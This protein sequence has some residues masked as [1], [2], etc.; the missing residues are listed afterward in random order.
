MNKHRGKR[1]FA[2]M[3]ALSVLLS[4]NGI[5][6]S[7]QIKGE[8][9][10]MATE[11]GEQEKKV[12]GNPEH[13][14]TMG[15]KTEWSYVYFGS[16]PQTEVT[17][18]SVIEAIEK[19]IPASAS[20]TGDGVDA[21]V[22][23]ESGVK[24]KYRRIGKGDAQD[25]RFE[26][27]EYRY[28][29]YEPI[30]WK[31]LWNDGKSLF[32]VAEKALDYKIYDTATENVTWE[33]C[34]VRKW[35]NESFYQA[36]FD[37]EEQKAIVTWDV[38]NEDHPDPK[39]GTEGGNDTRDNIYLLSLSEVMDET[40]GFCR[41]EDESVSRKAKESGFC[42]IRGTNYMGEMAKWRLRSPG[43]YN[44]FAMY[45]GFRGEVDKKGQNVSQIYE[46]AIC[47]S[48][49]INLSSELWS[50]ELDEAGSAEKIIPQNPAHNCVWDDCTEWN[51]VNFGSYPQ[52]EVTD[53]A[54]INNIDRV[55]S[56]SDGEEVWDVELPDAKGAKVKYRRI[57]KEGYYGDQF[58]YFKWEPIRWRVLQ[59][60]G[61]SLF[62]LADRALDYKG[63]NLEW[64]T[65]DLREW[66]NESFYQAAF[67]G[68]E[69]NAIIE[70]NVKNSDTPFAGKDTK[71]KIYVPS[72]A[73]II[74]ETYG[75]CSDEIVDSPTRQMKTSDYGKVMGVD[76]F[77]GSKRNCKWWLRSPG[78]LQ[79]SS[80]IWH[81]GCIMRSL[82]ASRPG[83]GVCPVLHVSVSSDT[84]SLEEN[85]GTGNQDQ[86]ILT[87]LRAGKTKTEYV[88][89]EELE[90]D[91]L[92][93]TAVY[94][95]SA[96]VLSA[97]DYTVN[98]EDISMNVPGIYALE[99]SYTEDDVTVKTNVSIIVKDDGKTDMSTLTV[100]FKDGGEYEYTGAVIQPQATVK[101]GDTSLVCGSDFSAEYPSDAEMTGVGVK[102]VIVKPA[103]NSN[104]KNIKTATYKIKER[105][106]TEDNTEI[107]VTPSGEQANPK[108][109]VTVTVDNYANK[110][111]GQGD[112]KITHNLTEG[113]DYAVEY[114]TGDKAGT[115]TITGK[116]NYAG[117]V[118]KAPE[119][120]VTKTSLADAVV[121]IPNCIY[122]KKEQK[123]EVTVK[124]GDETLAK[125]TDYT[126]SYENN[127]NAG[128][129]KAVITSVEGSAYTGTAVKKFT[130]N[131]ASATITAKDIT[132]IIGEKD[133]HFGAKVDSNGTLS[134]TSK[135]T[136]V[137]KAVKGKAKIVGLGTAEI[138]INAAPTL[139]Y[140]GASKT[141]TIK[142]T[143]PNKATLSK[144][145]SKKTGQLKVTWKKDTKATGYK[146]MYSTD[147]KFKNKKTT[148]TIA[149]K[150]NK[151]VSRIIKKLKKGKKYYVKVCA[152]VKV[153]K[154]EYLGA[155]SKVKNVKVKK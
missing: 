140:K 131:K 71:D 153:G 35:L 87:G 137:I 145:E 129:A 124:V 36:A 32:V 117:S 76:T 1:F 6:Q 41:D 73:E 72:I 154:K 67:Q 106:L 29:K 93:V 44:N 143:K 135:N 49:H 9:E 17:D 113:T 7:A 53:T 119:Q 96:K 123:P 102:T 78:N 24:A 104:Y 30:R 146:V 39:Y 64:E 136:K 68:E 97:Q 56:A 50:T 108:V 11:T 134:Y 23:D 15:E 33:T 95:K 147:K 43:I 115:V 10:V 34:A 74:D 118:V 37:K 5:V 99:V 12:P 98:A 91:D 55:I 45:V 28:F 80:G 138:T 86:E 61:K 120:E 42:N 31:V 155:Y 109:S 122:N 103:E 132:K 46:S 13:S 84:W 38:K 81:T 94:K 142:V 89:G 92:G 65:C 75:F 150:K 85:D 47:P 25:K 114:G 141:I 60:D 58:Y 125:G 121:T 101:N 90:L 51:Y 66:L 149:V 148:K 130:I 152:Y 126:V 88:Q 116:G 105:T 100:T 14:C 16:Y 139:N 26:K 52:A 63:R 127:K 110:W 82:G 20:S 107:T 70:W 83:A 133:F 40:Y 19:A 3:F 27:N 54:L 48:L 111:H 22:T 69:K 62:L 128:T 112:A 151:T 59:N 77:G 144:V 21:E 8:N 4:S 79:A 57:V 18:S 2:L